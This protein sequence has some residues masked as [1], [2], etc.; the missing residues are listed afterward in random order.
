[1][2]KFFYA[3]AVASLVA[4]FPLPYGYYTLLRIVVTI[5]CIVYLASNYEGE[6]TRGVV[7][8]GVI[9]ILFN[10]LIPIWLSKPIWIPIDIVVACVFGYA[11]YS[12]EE[13]SGTASNSGQKNITKQNIGNQS[14]SKVPNSNNKP[15]KNDI[16]NK[17]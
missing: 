12:V 2:N 16:L 1:M 5:G 13:K 7:T 14:I 3:I 8:F 10:P 4:I 15:N 6:L 17:F 9:L 11:G